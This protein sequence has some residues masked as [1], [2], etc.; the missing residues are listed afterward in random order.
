VKSTNAM[1]A[2]TTYNYDLSKWNVSSVTDM[3]G[4]FYGDNEFNQDLCAWSNKISNTTYVDEMFYSTNCSVQ[5]NPDLNAVPR[6]PFC[7][8][9]V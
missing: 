6:G 1:F 7:F 3:G 9:C 2:F 5:S 8:N 4:M